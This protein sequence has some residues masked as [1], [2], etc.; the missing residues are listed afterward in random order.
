M[1]E[2]PYI[3]FGNDTL[4]KLPKVKKGDEVFCP[5]CNGRHVLV[6]CTMEGRPTDFILFYKCGNKDYLA[7]I[8][9]RLVAHTPPDCSGKV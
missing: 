8:N 2:T 9:G 4:C 5:H 6:G 1:G 3:G 7:A